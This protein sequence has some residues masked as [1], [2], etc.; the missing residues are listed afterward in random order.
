[1]AATTPS[2]IIFYQEPLISIAMPDIDSSPGVDIPVS[3]PLPPTLL[4]RVPNE[5][6]VRIFRYIILL[7]GY[8]LVKRSKFLIQTYI[9]SDDFELHGKVT[10]LPI[11]LS[12]R[13]FNNLAM[14]CFCNMNA[15][16]LGPNLKT[17]I[18]ESLIRLPPIHMRPCFRR[19]S[20]LFVINDWYHVGPNKEMR[21]IRSIP[22]LF[23]YNQT[24][25]LLRDLTNVKG[26]T[27]LEGLYIV[28][29]ASCEYDPC[30]TMYM[31]RHANIKITAGM[32]RAKM[33]VY[34][35]LSLL[36][37]V[38]PPIVIEQ[39]NNQGDPYCG[40]KVEPLPFAISPF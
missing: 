22:D 8:G 18:W 4:T 35:P 24:A 27:N 1:V 32:V 28:I 23:H 36:T 2:L 31:L 39:T 40:R 30:V 25:R 16:R 5:I 38:R 37:P 26:F 17:H 15:V 33:F 11:L 10:L 12:C 19:V 7:P 9:N 13:M 14:I 6:W 20:L 29:V 21:P 34:R 3:V